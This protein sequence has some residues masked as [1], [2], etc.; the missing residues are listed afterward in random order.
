MSHY[1]SDD[2]YPKSPGLQPIKIK[3]TPSPSPPPFPPQHSAPVVTQTVSP[4]TSSSRRRKRN[5][6]TR[7]SQGDTVLLSFL[8]PN[9]PDIARAAGE[10]ALNSDS[11]SDASEPEDDPPR[12][13]MQTDDRV[14]LAQAAIKSLNGDGRTTKLALAR[15]V[16]TVTEVRPEHDT[17]MDRHSPKS[18]VDDQ[19]PFTG[20]PTPDNF[21]KG[22]A[23]GPT[24]SS[25]T[26]TDHSPATSPNLRD[27]AIPD[28]QASPDERLPALQNPTS[29]HRDSTAGSPNQSLPSFRH[30]SEIAEQATQEN[31]H[32]ASI[33]HRASFSH[34]PSIS[35]TGAPAL[36]PTLVSRFPPN[37]N[38]RRSPPSQF[39]PLNNPL[40]PVNSHAGTDIKLSPPT[41]S[42]YAA[43]RRH[44]SLS[45]TSNTTF[46]PPLTLSTTT[47][48][49]SYGSRGSDAYAHSPPTRPRSDSHRMSID[50]IT[51]PNPAAQ[52]QH[53]PPHGSTGFKC[54]YP[55]CNAPP[56]QTQYLLNSHA[57]VHSQAR[58]HYCP[59]PGCSRGEGGKGFKRKNEMIRHGLVHDSPGYVCPFCPE[60]D[61][62]YP[63]PDNLQRHVRVHHVDKDKDDPQLRE[64]LAQRP[65]GGGRGRRRRIGS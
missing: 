58:P 17:D 64:V 9:R 57:N 38:S 11:D 42:H 35:S 18:R 59:V 33:D 6:R 44:S 3:S 47:T 7:P 14:R 21:P 2:A 12:S 24:P 55:G 31:E 16:A 63:R 22:S 28:S 5:N 10:R 20:L 50:G 23:D 62:K 25:T 13:P 1:D 56:F 46:P 32:R 34:R 27:L 37:G 51:H 52:I 19:P 54:D 43:S 61:H 41:Y 30:L 29:P 45:D 48:N 15:P 49:E 36:S 4:T 65:E 26:R 40:S 39:P 60:R 53:V 8:E